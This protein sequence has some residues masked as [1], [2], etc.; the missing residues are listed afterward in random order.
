MPDDPDMCIGT[1]VEGPDTDDTGAIGFAASSIPGLRPD[2]LDWDLGT[3]PATWAPA[4]KCSMMLLT[5]FPEA[6]KA[7]CRPI[8]LG[9]HAADVVC[10]NPGDSGLAS[11]GDKPK[12]L[13]P[14]W[15]EPLAAIATRARAHT[16]APKGARHLKNVC[17]KFLGLLADST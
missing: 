7:F 13:E 3:M 1:L 12:L 17:G 5:L 6:F 4:S 10:T 2:K 8:A 16:Y 11:S 15:S 9:G 14:L